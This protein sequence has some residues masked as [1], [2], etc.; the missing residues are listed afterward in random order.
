MYYKI[1][2]WARNELIDGGFVDEP[3][4]MAVDLVN[5]LERLFTEIASDL[6]RKIGFSQL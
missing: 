1:R 6:P 2:F 5:A 3:L 4:K